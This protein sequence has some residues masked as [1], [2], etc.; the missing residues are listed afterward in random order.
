MP[1]S[2]RPSGHPNDPHAALLV[3]LTARL[4]R[5]CPWDRAQ[6]LESAR[7]YLLEEAHEVL[8]QLDAVVVGGATAQ[9]L[10]ALRDELGDL[11]FQVSF[12]AS[13]ASDLPGGFN[14]DDV[15]DTLLHKMIDRH[16]HVFAP[17]TTPDTFAREPLALPPQTGA[18]DGGTLGAWEARK[19][20]GRPAGASRID[21]VPTAIPALLRA[22]R[23]GEKLAH[24]GFDWPD[25]DGVF[26]KVDEERTELVEAIASGDAAAIRHEYGDLLLACASLGRFLGTPAEDAL[27]EANQRF[28]GRFRS[29]ERLAASD[30]TA[31]EGAT[32]AELDVLWRRVK[33][34][35]A[36]A[37]PSAGK[38]GVIPD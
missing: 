26:A 24:L 19:A 17:G 23:V 28:E 34:L 22:H 21:G 20:A 33:A 27:R 31:L 35:A 6:T 4:R 9:A 3:Q 12:L 11:L 29:L 10:A 13:M 1:P 14:L 30:G 32:P 18:A 36:N 38:T 8:Q 25:V 7:P 5:D 15:V 37:G 2:P 16:P